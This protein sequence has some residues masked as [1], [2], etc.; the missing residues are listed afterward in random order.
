MKFRKVGVGYREFTELAK[1]QPG[2]ELDL[3]IYEDSDILPGT[4]FTIQY[5]DEPEDSPVP[6]PHELTVEIVS[7]NPFNRGLFLVKRID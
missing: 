2:E 3:N 1:L 6:E 4:I 7:E 5:V